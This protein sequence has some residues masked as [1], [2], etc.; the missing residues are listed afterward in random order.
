MKNTVLFILML[1]GFLLPTP[2]ATAQGNLII[3]PRRVVF[4]GNKRTQELNLANTGTDSAKYL[5]SVVQYR[6]KDNGTFESITQPDSGQY[7]ADKNFRFFPRSVVLAPN[8]AQTVKIQL[9]NTSELEAGEYRSHLYFRAV[10]K[11]VPLTEKVVEKDSKDISIR[12]VPVFGIALPVIIRKGVSTT[13]VTIQN[14]SLIINPSEVPQLKL[15]FSRSGNMSVYGDITVDHVSPQ[16]KKTRVG[17]AKGFAIYTPN[18][19]LTFN[20]KLNKNLN[21]DYHKGKLHIVYATP[22]DAKFVK[23]AETELV[24]N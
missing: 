14:P 5:I 8:E 7:F 10:P 18:K 1:S 9:S 11:E 4:E 19:S 23:I 2:K 13:N 6:M 3:I 12:L 17:I 20:V 24:L 22:P 15:F 21:V 16:G